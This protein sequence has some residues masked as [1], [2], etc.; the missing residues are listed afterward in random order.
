M[1]EEFQVRD[2][3]TGEVRSAQKSQTIRESRLLDGTI[4]RIPLLPS[5]H[6]DDGRRLNTSDHETFVS[7]DGLHRFKRI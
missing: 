6:L 5:Y 7:S 1:I 2:V 3:A 4:S